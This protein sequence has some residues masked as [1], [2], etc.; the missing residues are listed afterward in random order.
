MAKSK[1]PDGAAEA[2]SSLSAPVRRA[3]ALLSEPTPDAAHGGTSRPVA[4]AYRAFLEAREG[5]RPDDARAPIGDLHRPI[6]SAT[7]AALVAYHHPA[8]WRTDGRPV[9][10]LPAE[11][12]HHLSTALGDLV[13]GKLPATWKATVKAS[14]P[15]TPGYNDDVTAAVRYVRAVK[16]G[17]IADRKHA[18]TVAA[19][20]GVAPTDV[21]RWNR[22][23]P[24][25]S[26]LPDAG[27]ETEAETIRT[28]MVTAG[29]HYQA[30]KNTK[31]HPR[32]V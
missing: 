19:A 28:L 5:I 26:P 15:A 21:H 23:T 25:L 3:A 9:E 17:V 8:N 14:R 32:G 31:R 1:A 30:F 29:K 24:D 16:A 13:A 4:A 18:A 2:T 7:L 6:W 10:A 22:G 11:M 27:E 20:F 12:A